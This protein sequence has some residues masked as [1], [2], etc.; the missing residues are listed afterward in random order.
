MCTPDGASG[1]VQ[2]LCD[3]NGRRIVVSTPAGELELER[4]ADSAWL[5]RVPSVAILADHCVDRADPR[6]AD[7]PCEW[8]GWA[9]TSYV[10]QPCPNGCRAVVV[11][12]YP[13]PVAARLPTAR[14]LPR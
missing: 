8:S 2:R 13:L 6:D 9:A 12:E 10:N 7:R 1:I 3:P 11:L 4:A 5:E 14:P